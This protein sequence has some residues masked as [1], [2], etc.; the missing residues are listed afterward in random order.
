MSNPVQGVEVVNV[1]EADEDEVR[2][3]ANL[4]VASVAVAVEDV[5]TD[6]VAEVRVSIVATSVE[7]VADAIP[8]RSTCPIPAPSQVSGDNS[9]ATIIGCE[10]V[11]ITPR[12]LFHLAECI[13]LILKGLSWISRVGGSEF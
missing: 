13:F 6:F 1:D 2:A 12:S 10:F 5:A 7:D 4:E 3:E 11:I 8:A 9:T